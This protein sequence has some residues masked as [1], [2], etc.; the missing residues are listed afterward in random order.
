MQ[1]PSQYFV[2]TRCKQATIRRKRNSVF[3][4]LRKRH[5]ASSNVDR[6]AAN[7]LIGPARSVRGASSVRLGAVAEIYIEQ[8]IRE[9]KRAA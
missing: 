6:W 4:A 5:H 2:C 7:V 3:P 1:A 8:R 9:A